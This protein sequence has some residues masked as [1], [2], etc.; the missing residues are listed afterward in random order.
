MERE[1]GGERGREGGG[2]GGKDK[3]RQGGREGRREEGGTSV[4]SIE[5]QWNAQ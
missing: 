1:G 5:Q 2:D 4:N 3:V